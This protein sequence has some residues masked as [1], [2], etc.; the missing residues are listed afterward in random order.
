MR[1]DG[2]ITP[3]QL[4]ERHPEMADLEMVIYTSAG[5][6]EYVGCNASV[7]IGQD[8]SDPHMDVDDPRNIATDVLVFAPN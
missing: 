1:V 5:E 7:Y 4:I 3:R 6:Y 8:H 2:P